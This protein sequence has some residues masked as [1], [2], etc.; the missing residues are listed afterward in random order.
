MV[1]FV[2]VGGL[3]VGA[4]VDKGVGISVVVAVGGKVGVAISSVANSLEA[5]VVAAGQGVGVGVDDELAIGEV[6]EAQGK[7]SKVEKPTFADM[8]AA[9]D[10]GDANCPTGHILSAGGFLTRLWTSAARSPDT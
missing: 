4:E 6:L 3:G 9:L 1:G 5:S 10:K 2:V 7:D 8:Q